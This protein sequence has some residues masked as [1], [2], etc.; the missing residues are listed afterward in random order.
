[1]PPPAAM[2]LVDVNGNGDGW[3]NVSPFGDNG[4]GAYV[5][6]P[7]GEQAYGYGGAWGYLYFNAIFSGMNTVRSVD[8]YYIHGRWWHPD[9]GLFL[10]PNDKGDYLFG[11]DGPDPVNK[12][13]VPLLMPQLQLPNNGYINTPNYGFLD[14]R[15]MNEARDVTNTILEFMNDMTKPNPLPL[16]AVG[17]GKAGAGRDLRV[18]NYFEGLNAWYDINR[19]VPTQLQDKVALGILLDYERRWENLQGRS[20]TQAGS[21]YSPEDLPSDYLGFYSAISGMNVP[22]VLDDILKGKGKHNTQNDK[23]WWLDSRTGRIP[24]KTIDPVVCRFDW[25]LRW[26]WGEKCATNPWPDM[27]RI[28]EETQGIYWQLDHCE[29][30]STLD[31]GPFHRRDPNLGCR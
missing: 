14:I 21:S 10:S 6:S 28:R 16:T 4:N 7:N 15:H 22:V 20:I 8:L 31:L 17:T 12:G 27:M 13:W 24:N 23:P 19:P 25:G 5:A 30:Y 29:G 9:M 1:M 2:S 11:G 18:V 3:N 26:D